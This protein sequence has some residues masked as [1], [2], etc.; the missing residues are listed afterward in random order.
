M[1]ITLIARYHARWYSTSITKLRTRSIIDLGQYPYSLCT[2]DIV[3]ISRSYTY[4][5]DK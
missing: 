2:Y 3:P 4:T 5:W 1:N